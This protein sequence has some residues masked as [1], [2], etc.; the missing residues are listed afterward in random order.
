MK[1]K[2][3]VDRTGIPHGTRKHVRGMH[4]VFHH[5][6]LLVYLPRRNH[7]GSRIQMLH[8]SRSSRPCR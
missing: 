5:L 6:F 7:L 4:L 1:V 3:Y 2:A 8:A